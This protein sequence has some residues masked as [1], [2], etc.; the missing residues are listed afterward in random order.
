M[1]IAILALLLLGPKK[2]PELARTLGKVMR[3]LQAAADDV[4]RELTTPVEDVKR[5]F[6]APVDSLKQE[7]EKYIDE[8]YHAAGIGDGG[9][10]ARAGE[11][12]PPEGPARHPE[13]SATK[14][15]PAPAAGVRPPPG[16]EKLSG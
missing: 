5:E 3:D 10:G 13:K 9:A 2:I 16:G 15:N 4:K 8:A 11:I 1:V 14:E 6:K 7:T 12:P